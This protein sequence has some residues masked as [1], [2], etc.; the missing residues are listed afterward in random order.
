MSKT[1]VKFFVVYD[2]HFLGYCDAFV[3]KI[4]FLICFFFN[5]RQISRLDLIVLLSVLDMY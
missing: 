1:P 2:E 5:F 4:I 3:F